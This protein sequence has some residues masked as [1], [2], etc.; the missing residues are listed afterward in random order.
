MLL[1]QHGCYEKEYDHLIPE[2]VAKSKVFAL[3]TSKLFPSDVPKIV[4]VFF[5]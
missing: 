2:A 1:K 4:D 3:D 5:T